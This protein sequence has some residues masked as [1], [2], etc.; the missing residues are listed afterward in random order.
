[1]TAV[2]AACFTVLLSPHVPAVTGVPHE[3]PLVLT[4]ME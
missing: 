2:N 4:E 1:L 3:V